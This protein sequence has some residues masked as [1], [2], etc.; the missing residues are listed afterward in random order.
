MNDPSFLKRA[1]GERLAYRFDKGRGPGIVWLGG[2]HS[3]MDG[4]KAQAVGAWA[5]KSRHACLRFDYFGHGLSSGAF[6]DGTISRWRDDALAALDELTHGPQVLV[7][8]SMGGWIATLLAHQRPER[9]AAMLLIAPAPDFTEVLAWELMPP[10][11]R[12]DVMEQG[13]WMRPSEYE[14][15][16]PITRALIEDGRRNFVLDKPLRLSFPVRILHGEADRDVPW[17]HGYRLLDVMLGDVNF[18]LV[19]GADHRLSSPEH[20]K[21]IES[22]LES[23]MQEIAP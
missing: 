11:I 15:P 22:G 18:M 23:L 13:Y 7:A 14:E 3:S 4:V 21:L 9:I 17:E 12:K 1:D 2:F 16:Y 8:S 6:M 20:L 10:A 19:K 5:R